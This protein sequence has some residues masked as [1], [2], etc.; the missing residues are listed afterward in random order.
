MAYARSGPL[1]RMMWAVDLAIALT[2]RRIMPA[3]FSALILQAVLGAAPEA[4]TLELWA[5]DPLVKVF[6]DFKPV[7]GEALADAA[8]G[9]HASLQAVA[10][11]SV[12][13]KKMKGEA[14]PLALEGDAAKTLKAIVRFV[15]YVPV[16]AGIPRPP[17]DRLRIAPAFFPDPLLEKSEITVTAGSAQPVWITVAVPPH[18]AP[19]LYRGNLRVN[20]SA[21]DKGLSASIPIA[22]RVWPVVMKKPRLWVTNWFQMGALPTFTD[23]GRY[24]G[25]R[26]LKTDSDDYWAMLRKYARNMADHRQ[27]VALISPLGLAEFKPRD[28]GGFDIDFSRFDRWVRIFTEE[29]VIGRIEGGHIGGRASGWESQF[30]VNIR[31]VKDG[32]IEGASVDPATPE[33]EAFYAIFFPA[34]V[35]HLREKGWLDIYT[36]H[37]ADEPIDMNVQTYRP[38]AALLRKHAPEFRVVEACHTKDLTGSIQ[39]WVPQ[40]NFLHTDFAHYRERQAAGD[41]IWYYT[42]LGPQG[43]YANRFIEQPLMKTRLLHWI[44][45]KYGVTGY[46]HWGYNYWGDYDPYRQLAIPW[47]GGLQHLPAGDAWIVY[48]GKEGPLDSIRFEAMRDGIDDYELLSMLAD[49]DK[50]TAGRFAAAHV[51]DFDKYD[52]DVA[53]FRATRRQLLEALSGR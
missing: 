46:L 8:C 14:A 29:G 31:R 4:P 17:K 5:V 44:N 53:K 45:F 49:K 19:G 25:K 50:E 42:C 30:V 22:V 7:A 26:E 28:G 11:C 10:R 24:S 18:A 48:P 41:E 2:R 16:E 33:A 27:N 9:E 40:L 51:L 12:L 34:L 38:M 3:A 47:D 13:A 1:P 37:L 52:C 43:E 36:Q 23:L 20:A 6:P 21:E 15:G 32:K 39:V 35:R